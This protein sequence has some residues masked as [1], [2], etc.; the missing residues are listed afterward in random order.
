[1]D[2][3]NRNKYGNRSMSKSKK[4]ALVFLC[5]TTVIML[6]KGLV[7][8][9][10]TSGTVYGTEFSMLITLSNQFSYFMVWLASLTAY[11][12]IDAVFKLFSKSGNKVEAG[13]GA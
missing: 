2:S 6:Y 4:A 11:L 5:L 1:M 8:A 10:A 12:H 13:Q 7:I 9:S 3:V